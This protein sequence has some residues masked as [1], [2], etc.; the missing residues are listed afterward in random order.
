MVIYGHFA[1]LN[2][3]LHVF[4]IVQPYRCGHT[5]L[6]VVLGKTCGSLDEIPSVTM[7]SCKSKTLNEF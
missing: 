5:C 1:Q 7:G 4:N 6:C 2:Y 3:D